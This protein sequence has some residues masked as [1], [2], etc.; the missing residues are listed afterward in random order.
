MACAAGVT[1]QQLCEQQ[2]SVP[3][4]GG[5][6][7][8]DA[9]CKTCADVRCPG[10]AGVKCIEALPRCV[11]GPCC[12]IVQCGYDCQTKEVWTPEKSAWCCANQGVGCGSTASPAAPKCSSCATTLCPALAGMQCIEEKV[13]CFA[14]PCCP[15]VECGYDCRTKELWSQEKSKWCCDRRGVGCADGSHD[16]SGSHSHDHGS[17]S[18]SDWWGGSHDHSGSHEHSDWGSLSRDHDHG[19]YEHGSHS[20]EHGS[21]SH[22]HGSH[23]HEHGSHSHDH[24]SHSHEHGSHSHDHGSHSHEHG[25]HSHEHGSHSHDHG[26]HSHEHGSH[27]H[28]HGSH[29]HE[30][31]SHGHDH[32]SHSHEHGSGSWGWPWGGSRDHGS[33]DGSWGSWGGS[34]DGS[35]WDGGFGGG[36]CELAEVEGMS[37]RIGDAAFCGSDDAQ[38]DCKKLAAAEEL[39]SKCWAFGAATDM[40]RRTVGGLKERC[41]KAKGASMCCMAMTADCLA[42][43]KGVSVQEYCA[44]GTAMGCSRSDGTAARPVKR[45]CCRA[46]TATCMACAAGK[47]VKEYCATDEGAMVPGCMEAVG[48][49]VAGLPDAAALMPSVDRCAGLATETECMMQGGRCKW[50]DGACA[51]ERDCWEE[52]GEGCAKRKG[53]KVVAGDVCVPDGAVRIDGVE[54]P[55]ADDKKRGTEGEGGGFG[56]MLCVRL[57]A[58]ECE[59]AELGGVAC[60]AVKFGDSTR[61]VSAEAA[62]HIVAVRG[63]ASEK[64]QHWREMAMTVKDGAGAMLK[65][66][67]AAADRVKADLKAALG[68]SFDAASAEVELIPDEDGVRVLV[69]A[70]SAGG[71]AADELMGRFEELQRRGDLELES[72]AQMLG[73]TAAD[74][75]DRADSEHMM[76]RWRDERMDKLRDMRDMMMK[77][78]GDSWRRKRD[79]ASEAASKAGAVAQELTAA[80]KECSADFVSGALSKGDCSF[81]SKCAERLAG[82]AEDSRAMEV[83]PASVLAVVQKASALCDKVEDESVCEALKSK[84][85][86]TLAAARGGLSK[87]DGAALKKMCRVAGAV[88]SKL[89][90]YHEQMRY[91]GM[92]PT[93]EEAGEVR[94]IGALCAS[95][96]SDSNPG[97]EELCALSSSHGGSVER[98]VKDELQQSQWGDVC[99]SPCAR[100]V[101]AASAKTEAE[102]QSLRLRCVRPKGGS[103]SCD[104]L[105]GELP[106]VDGKSV[107]EVLGRGEEGAECWPANV[108]WNSSACPAKCSRALAA[109][110]AVGCCGGELQ[111]EWVRG[112]EADAAELSFAVR[113]KCGG[114]VANECGVEEVAGP[115]AGSKKTRREPFSVTVAA[116]ADVVEGMAERLRGAFQDD[117]A[118]I[119]GVPVQRV[120]LDSVEVTTVTADVSVLSGELVDDAERPVLAPQLR[121]MMRDG[122]LEL[123]S[124]TDAIS[125][126]GR[127]VRVPKAARET[128]PRPP[129]WAAKE[130]GGS[131][132]G[133]AASLD[134]LA[135]RSG[136]SKKR[137]AFLGSLRNRS[138]SEGE[139]QAAGDAFCSGAKHEEIEAALPE[140]W[141][142][143][144]APQAA[145]LCMYA[146]VPALCTRVEGATAAAGRKGGV[147]QREQASALALVSAAKGARDMVA[148]FKAKSKM[149]RGELESR[150]V[151]AA[152]A[153]RE[154]AAG[155][156]KKAAAMMEAAGVHSETDRVEDALSKGLEEIMCMRGQSRSSGSGSSSGRQYLLED[157][158]FKE[159]V[160]S[161]EAMFGAGGFAPADVCDGE[162]HTQVRAAAHKMADAFSSLSSRRVVDVPHFK[163][164]CVKHSHDMGKDKGYCHTLFRK[165]RGALSDSCHPSKLALKESADC[166]AK[167]TCAVDET[168]LTECVSEL[169]D[170]TGQL[171]CC[172]QAEMAALTQRMWGAPKKQVEKMYDAVMQKVGGKLAACPQKPLPAEGS[173][174][175]KKRTTTLKMKVRKV[176]LDTMTKGRSEE[177][178]KEEMQSV[179]AAD[180]LAASGLHPNELAEVELW[181]APSGQT[182]QKWTA[183]GSLRSARR[184]QAPTVETVELRA[185]VGCD[186]EAHCAEVREQFGGS[187]GW[188]STAA[189]KSSYQ[190]S[191]FDPADVS[192][193][194]EEGTETLGAANGES[195]SSEGGEGDDSGDSKGKII[196]AVAAA[197]GGLGLCAGVALFARSRAGKPSPQHPLANM[198]E[199]TEEGAAVYRES[200]RRGDPALQ[201]SSI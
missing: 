98:A 179:L 173:E 58:D 133:C 10:T 187:C 109:A 14:P 152:K 178:V 119:L 3:G 123:P 124:V 45:V 118:G 40:C 103:R 142:K 44:S 134:A 73:K 158:K 34:Q 177:E 39:C 164:M 4:C 71:E 16:A 12:P 104:S 11:R 26:S 140:A 105:I 38:C 156:K 92:P 110:A 131:Y 55:G 41:M 84:V 201:T 180:V 172:L 5:G 22:E 59:R 132:D 88:R 9:L 75:V 196:G 97:R 86:P 80:L 83:L 74:V 170:Y 117:V 47:S 43:A 33:H 70:A 21:H 53:C 137:N 27:S 161:A 72:T 79:S 87:V 6:S 67:A 102:K 69:K 183:R 160:A 149:E 36:V 49:L 18:W 136:D 200:P 113:T 121:G 125:S 30:H 76:E 184:L 167:G 32:G 56:E 129:A 155:A 181:R 28:D 185:A 78:G 90:Q 93:E 162:K 50:G 128:A 48:D 24:G 81:C 52:S 68:D 61:C 153:V 57:E 100:K 65:D 198:K 174:E 95:G 106:T 15:I 163:A 96:P 1:V 146:K 126:A 189:M 7:G 169:R 89:G 122:A 166:V 64:K 8:S 116:G 13:Q 20:H 138:A 19:S 159:K 157:E 107:R 130:T 143:C 182:L 141:S 192:C 199:L 42:C 63:A 193:S 25:S 114:E 127:G 197:V 46:R 176:G 108:M 165:A 186:S 99:S 35:W 148:S 139:M 151:G 168:A 190:G 51:S 82:V 31:G 2:P 91:L 115:A 154:G 23:S 94:R 175:R 195:P 191:L 145:K 29:S 17:G 194:S 54:T 37:K 66:K 101:A 85:R 150:C 147:Q 135:K 188:E 62:E 120:P 112:G 111:Q 144:G 60:K 77:K 171:G